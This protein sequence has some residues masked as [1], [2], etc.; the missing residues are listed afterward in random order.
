M[1]GPGVSGEFKVNVDLTQGSALINLISI[2][3][4]P[5]PLCELNDI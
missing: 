2:G 3:V 1:C 4:G 5:M